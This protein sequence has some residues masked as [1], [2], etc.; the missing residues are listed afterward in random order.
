[1]KIIFSVC[2]FILLALGCIGLALPVLPSTPFFLGAGF[3]FVKSSRR[4]N[5]WF[6]ETRLYKKYIRDLVLDKKMTTRGKTLLVISFTLVMATGFVLMR[7][8]V[9][10]RVILVV[11]WVVHLVYFIWGIKTDRSGDT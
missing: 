6:V 8:F 3:C 1:M 11:V 4:L 10:G 2:A 9:P 7:F 5:E